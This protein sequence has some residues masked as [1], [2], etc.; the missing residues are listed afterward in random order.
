MLKHSKSILVSVAACLVA[1]NLCMA[2]LAS[3]SGTYYGGGQL[4]DADTSKLFYPHV[5]PVV[6]KGT[7]DLSQSAGNKAII[8][9]LIDKDVY[10]L[11]PFTWSTA[12][13]SVGAYFRK[14]NDGTASVGFSDGNSLDDGVDLCQQYVWR[15]TNDNVFTF[16]LTISETATLSVWGNGGAFATKELDYLTQVLPYDTPNELSA[17]GYLWAWG[18]DA[19]NPG[20]IK[21]SAYVVPAPA[22]A[23]LAFIGLGLVGWVR[24]RI[25]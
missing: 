1:A 6:I 18:Y 23:A 12:A 21:Y 19:Q 13:Q 15:T 9:G 25:A 8:I 7:V 5:H 3:I 22:A 14:N 11:V 20:G 24:R 2:S 16:E 17:G 10:N 4:Q